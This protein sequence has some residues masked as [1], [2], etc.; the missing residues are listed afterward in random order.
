M[1]SM[2][3]AAPG[4]VCIGE[5]PVPKAGHM[6][7]RVFRVWLAMLVLLIL[8]AL[9]AAEANPRLASLRIDIWPEFDRQAALIILKGE[10]SPD[11]PLPAEVSLRIPA[12]AGGPSAVAFAS[13]AGSELLNM[14]HTVTRTG[15]YNTLRFAAPQR[16]FHIEYYD[17]LATG[18]SVR[19]YTYV[20]PGDLAVDR[21]NVTLQEP[22]T[23]SDVSA[24]PDLGPS[25]AG[26]DGMFYRSLD[27][28]AYEAGKPLPIAIRYT[29]P[30]SRTSAE[31]LKMKS[32]AAKTP[33]PTGSTGSYPVWVPLAATL[34]GLSVVMPALW[35]VWRRRKVARGSKPMI[36]GFCFQCGAAL[37][38]GNRY[39]S[40]C[41]TPVQQG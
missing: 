24:L 20:W 27:L 23:A 15:D 21:L 31:I 1:S 29:K 12:S 5:T 28:G 3:R 37:R 34:L 41:G 17:A 14:Q 10:L 4:W 11:T 13:A 35:W 22:A 38:P 7:A 32:P 16:F 19:T 39:C 2:V 25:A 8:P 9:A 40:S 26:G 6:T 30:D 36:A 33:G 18:S